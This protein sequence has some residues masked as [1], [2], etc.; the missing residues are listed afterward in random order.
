MND[1]S[2]P[3]N[4]KADEQI[5]N[6]AIKR[7]GDLNPAS[8]EPGIYKG[9]PFH[10]Y[11]ITNALNSSKVRRACDSMLAYKRYVIELQE[12]T[13]SYALEF[14]RAFALM[15]Q[16][17]QSLGDIIKPGATKTEFTKAWMEDMVANP[18]I[19]YVKEKD[20]PMLEAMLKAFQSHP[21]TKQYSY[22]AYNE[23]M[24][25]WKCKYT[26]VLC[27]ALID[28][29]KDGH[30]IDVKT[31]ANV[32]PHKIKWQVRDLR[33]DIQL[34]FYADGLKA[35]GVKVDRVSNFFIEKLDLLPDVV[36]KGYNEERLDECRREYT[37]AIGNINEAEKTGFYPGYATEPIV[38]LFGFDEVTAE[39]N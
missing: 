9:I 35:N 14:G 15:C 6:V 13:P 25:V 37:E 10:S 12:D 19:I 17:P 20:M 3:V 4:S 38:D 27:K 8:P 18:G 21:Y 22:D 31:A 2:S 7:A 30:V 39:Y 32:K 29:F 26:G 16:F 36:P 5:D 24:V 34:C 23:L 28:I 1:D 33:Y 11:Q